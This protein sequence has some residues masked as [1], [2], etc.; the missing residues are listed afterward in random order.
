[1]IAHPYKIKNKMIAP[2]FPSSIRALIPKAKI[3]KELVIA[4]IKCLTTSIIQLLIQYART[5]TPETIC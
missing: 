4:G 5:E 3:N 1:M 2:K